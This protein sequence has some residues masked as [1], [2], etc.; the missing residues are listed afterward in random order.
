MQNIRPF[1][2]G[3]IAV[4]GF[5][6]ILS[7]IILAGFDVVNTEGENPYGDRVLIWGSVDQKAVEQT[8][9]DIARTDKQ[10][11]V[12]AYEWHDPRTFEEELVN[13]IAEDRAPDAILYTHDDLVT[14]RAKLWPIPYETWPLRTFKDS[15][16]DGAEIFARTD[17]VYAFPFAVDPLVMYWNRD[18]FSST[19]FPTPPATWES[20]VADTVPGITVQN[21]DR[22]I[23][24]SAVALGEYVNLV[25][26]KDILLMLMMQS[27]SKLV[28]ETDRGY[29]V[30]LDVPQVDGG[31]RPMDAAIQ[32][33]VNFSNTNSALYTWNRLPES[34]QASFLREDLALYFGR[35]S[36][37]G[38]IR[39]KNPNLNFDVA[40][41]P[42]GSTATIKRTYG[43][44][45]GFGI[46]RATANANGTYQALATLTSAESVEP[47]AER[48]AFAPVLRSSL[49]KATTD[50]ARQTIVTEALIAR[51]WL[52][53][54]S[55]GSDAIFRE[56]IDAIV[57]NR[58]KV[59]GAVT[60]ALRR[61]ELAF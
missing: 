30:A 16:I 23:K 47:L 15:Y 50:P 49:A 29:E 1:Q 37:A 53:P 61:L 11:S 42:Q 60:D 24:R 12:V 13:A 9:Q 18:L 45:Y 48:L 33:F 4:F 2:I 46:L 14:Y 19:G 3:I 36:E 17:G 6:A 41:V 7:V 52:D 27:G 39:E 21:T 40:P 31:R 5:L 55:T 22:S 59:A 34:D 28:L 38:S 56:M 57:S 8:L 51:G 43:T 25:N 10:F 35:G 32:F 26:A 44:F 20:L 58:A 54:D